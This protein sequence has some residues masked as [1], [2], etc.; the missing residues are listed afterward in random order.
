MSA[1]PLHG[2]K[3]ARGKAT[4]CIKNFIL[5]PR[6]GKKGNPKAQRMFARSEARRP[7]KRGSGRRSKSTSEQM[8]GVLVSCF[9][10]L[11][12]FLSSTPEIVHR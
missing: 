3:T 6:R 8:L 1:T 10:S 5:Q 4:I 7:W 12:L 2:L 11:L 9:L